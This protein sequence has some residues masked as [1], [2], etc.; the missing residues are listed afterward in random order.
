MM[1][2]RVNLQKMKWFKHSEFRDL[3]YYLFHFVFCA[4]T[5]ALVKR[6]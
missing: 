3:E 5:D 2:I 1:E 4:L 6:D